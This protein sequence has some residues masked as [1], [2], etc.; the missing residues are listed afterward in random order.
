MADFVRDYMAVK[1]AYL[2]KRS[3]TT[4][5]G[6]RN[7]STGQLLVPP[8]KLVPM[9]T[10]GDAMAVWANLKRI[11]EPTLTQCIAQ[12]QKS[13][14]VDALEARL[15]CIGSD[16]VKTSNWL[17]AKANFDAQNPMMKSGFGPQRLVSGEVY[18]HNEELWGYADDYVI[19]RGA[20]GAVPFKFDMAV[21]SIKEAIAEAPGLVRDAIRDAADK[22]AATGTTLRDILKWGAIGGGLFMLYWYVLRPKARGGG[23]AG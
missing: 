19:A 21:E 14:G 15:I 16:F 10:W 4:P 22:I 1:Q 3:G 13:R 18:P 9:T 8:P 11:A 7:R 20:A 17:R 23:Q 6:K 12:V 2:S 5:T